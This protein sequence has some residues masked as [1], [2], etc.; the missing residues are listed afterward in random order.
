[1][2]RI[3][4]PVSTRSAPLDGADQDTAAYVI[5]P[6]YADAAPTPQPPLPGTAAITITH[7]PGMRAPVEIPLT[8]DTILIGRHQDCDVVLADMTVS[9]RHAEIRRVGDAFTVTD[10]GSL[11]GTYVNRT[12]IDHSQLADGDVLLV[13]AFRLMFRSNPGEAVPTPLGAQPHTEAGG[14][15]R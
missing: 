4:E 13:G 9:R 15:T 12:P 14:W 2:V 11:N 5:P 3:A 1:M 10:L 7:G 6:R 8:A